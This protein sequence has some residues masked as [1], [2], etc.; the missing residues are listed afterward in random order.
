MKNYCCKNEHPEGTSAMVFPCM[1]FPGEKGIRA[2]D[3]DGDN[4]DGD[5]DDD[6]DDSD[7]VM[8]L[9][10]VV[11]MMEQITIIYHTEQDHHN[12]DHGASLS[13]SNKFQKVVQTTKL[14]FPQSNGK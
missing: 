3:D 6:Y 2:N 11:A 14:F 8:L 1:G 12:H 4:N 5:D 7:D 10:M 13:K 9:V